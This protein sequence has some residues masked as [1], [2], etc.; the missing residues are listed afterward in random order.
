MLLHGL[1]HKKDAMHMVGHQLESKDRHLRVMSL[2]SIPLLMHPLPQGRRLHP[3]VTPLGNKL[4]QQG[5]SALDSHRYEVH[6][7]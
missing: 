3:D 5:P 4:S 2:D 1:L 7:P 6:A